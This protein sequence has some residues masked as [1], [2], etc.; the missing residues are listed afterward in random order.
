MRTQLQTKQNMVSKQQDVDM[1]SVFTFLGHLHKLCVYILFSL[2]L[3]FACHDILATLT[4]APTVS[5]LRQVIL[6]QLCRNLYKAEQQWLSLSVWT[7]KQTNE[8]HGYTHS[9]PAESPHLKSVTLVNCVSF[10]DVYSYIFFPLPTKTERSSGATPPMT[11]KLQH[12][13]FVSPLT[14]DHIRDRWQFSAILKVTLLSFLYAW[15]H[16]WA[17]PLVA[18]VMG[19]LALSLFVLCTNTSILLSLI[20]PL[21]SPQRSFTWTQ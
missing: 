16:F 10:S 3:Q 6:T 5:W 13:V 4:L 12:P 17:A 1:L 15:Y 21:P 19:R 2:R 18:P 20:S 14:L 9:I 7:Q 8:P 11:Q